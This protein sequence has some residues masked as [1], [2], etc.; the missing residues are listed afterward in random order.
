MY[1]RSGGIINVHPTVDSTWHYPKRHLGGALDLA[2]TMYHISFPRAARE[3]AWLLEGCQGR[4]TI[5][6]NL[7]RKFLHRNIRNTVVT[8]NNDKCPH[9][10]W[11]CCDMSI[12][13][14]D[15]NGIHTGTSIFDQE[16]ERN[17][18]C[19]SVEGSR[20]IAESGERI[21]GLLPTSGQLQII[22]IPWPNSLCHIY[23]LASSSG[24]PKE[25]NE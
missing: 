6:T 8:L 21:V 15:L 19:L 22:K 5:Q 1:G 13:R 11:S 14:A 20:V 9:Q 2:P 24:Q 25:G 4:A 3:V 23:W 10:W 7:W 18:L 16:V 17:R 12:P